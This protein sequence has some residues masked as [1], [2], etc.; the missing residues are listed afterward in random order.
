M[1]INFQEAISEKFGNL[2]GREGSYD[3]TTLD[4]TR[5]VTHEV[6]REIPRISYVP[7]NGGDVK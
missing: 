3:E 4:E 5:R 2:T 6:S 7:R 1:E